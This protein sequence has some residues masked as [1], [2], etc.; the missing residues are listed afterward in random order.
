MLLNGNEGGNM[1]DN[2]AIDGN[3][4]I[5]LQEDVGNA[6]HLGKIWMYTIATG[7]LTLIAQHDPARFG[8]I[9]RNAVSPFNRDE[10]SSGVIDVSD[11]LGPGTFL[12]DVQAHYPINNSSPNGFANPNELVEGGQLLLLRVPVAPSN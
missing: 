3:G 12:L 9:G 1:Y 8:D 6:A 10:E 7:Q 2:I 4:R 11:I 5:I